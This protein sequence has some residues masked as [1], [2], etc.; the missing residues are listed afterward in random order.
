M[1]K[2]FKFLIRKY[3]CIFQ[4]LF[5]S[6][7]LI[8]KKLENKITIFCYHDITDNPSDFCIKYNLYVRLKNFKKQINYISKH[9]EIIDI[10]SLSD[11]S[12]ITPKNSAI[13]SFDDGFKGAFDNGLT[14]L[15]R[16]KI[17][18]VMFLNMDSVL[19]KNP[20]VS[21][22]AKYLEEN[23]SEY[24]LWNIKKNYHNH[25]H[26][27]EYSK[28]I[29]KENLRSFALD[30]QGLMANESD[31]LN[32]KNSKYATFSNHYFQH[33]DSRVLNKYEVEYQINE[34]E[35]KLKKYNNYAKFFAFTNGS[36]TKD[37]IC[38]IHSFKIFHKIL[39]S[40]G[41]ASTKDSLVLDR[42]AIDDSFVNKFSMKAALYKAIR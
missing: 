15:D 6:D 14:Y 16:I 5:I 31:L 34:N 35:I 2:E 3:I 25:I 21:A 24:S 10:R 30:Y 36:F 18:A 28:F 26:Y 38:L 13:I 37:Y 40:S 20:M 7:S 27:S 33:F 22:V 29:S 17:P 11:P 9:F 1:Y 8:V 12:F 41:T 19:N 23:K 42:I 39:T 4:G 32:L